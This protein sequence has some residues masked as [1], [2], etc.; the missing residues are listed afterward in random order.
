MEKAEL[1][2]KESIKLDA[3]DAD[4]N[5]ALGIFY[6]NKAVPVINERENT[7][8]VKQKKKFDDLNIKASE[9][10]NSAIKYYEAANTIRPN[11]VEILNFCKLTYAQLGQEQK[12]VEI[13]NKIKALNKAK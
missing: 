13:G 12:V 1:D 8:N 2:Y 7:D 3:G 5:I 11:D 4:V 10:L 6:F 9:L